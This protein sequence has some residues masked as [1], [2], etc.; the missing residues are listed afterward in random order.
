[1]PVLTN[2]DHKIT[3]E[4]QRWPAVLHPYMLAVTQLGNVGFVIVASLIIATIAYARHRLGLAIA[5]ACIVPAEF[6]NAG[7]K[8]LFDRARPNTEYAQAM[9]LHTTSFPSGHAFGSMVF[10]GL[11]AYLAFTRLP[12][13]LNMFVGFGLVALIVLIGISRIYLGAHYTFDV[14]GGWVVGAVV[15]AIIIKFTKL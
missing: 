2:I 5:F 14:L 3:F 10:Y 12:Q 8:L 1:M 11:L 7:L 4:L 13:A 15:L 6:F 9:V